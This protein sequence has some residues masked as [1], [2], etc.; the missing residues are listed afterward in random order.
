MFDSTGL[1]WKRFRSLRLVPALVI[2]LS[3]LAC[4]ATPTP[5]ETTAPPTET[6][7]VEP[8][9]TPTEATDEPTTSPVPGDTATPDEGPTPTVTP[10]DTTEG[11]LGEFA[12]W[13]KVEIELDGPDSESMSDEANPFKII[14]D[15]NFTAPEGEIYTVP[16]F[17]A[18]DGAGGLDGNL[19]QVRFAPD[20]AGLWTFETFSDEPLLDH[21]TGTFDAT[22]VT[23]CVEYEPGGMP[24]LS[25]VGRLQSV[26]ESYLRFADGTYWLKGGADEPEDFLAP[27]ETVGFESKEAAISYLAEQ[28]VN[29]LYMMLHNVGGDGR[30]VWPWVGETED[31]ARQ[32]HEH[33][34]I[35]KLERWEEVFS[36]AQEQGVLLHLVFEDDSAWNG[37]NREMYYREM[38][39]RF[40]HHNALYWN[41]A[42][43]YE[44][45]YRPDQIVA[46]AEMVAVLDAYDHPITVHHV[47]S[48][49]AWRPFVNDENFGITSFQTGDLPNVVNAIAAEWRGT[50]EEAE[51]IIPVSIDEAAEIETD[52]REL[53]RQLV[54]GTYTG[55][56]NFE[57][58][59]RFLEDFEDFELQFADMTLARRYIESLPFTEMQPM[60]ELLRGG[61]SYV[62]AQPGEVYT[63]YTLQAAPF[64]LD[65]SDAEGEFQASWLDPATG[66]ITEEGAVM[67]G[68]SVEF[69][70][71]LEGDSVLY[72]GREPLTERWEP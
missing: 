4:V 25:C 32:N 51:R 20:A 16:A 29:S 36:H 61:E 55:G 21:R 59:T 1:V 13:S 41:L 27:D 68:E 23:G 70:P 50:F 71:P 62:F 47:G 53:S 8:G 37:F 64:E 42:E 18:G 12:V 48:T 66:E 19:W 34:D 40:G 24:D 72:L 22:P 44:E 30:N 35:A 57:M 26:G 67:G 10:P 43:E 3:G 60:N 9:E 63:V 7:T 69:Q 52:M 2:A 11:H 33:F 17:Y 5:T 38:I 46:F 31:E 28:G 49:D 39:A 54:W 14:L 58:F 56:G 6:E 15:V 65:L 45:L